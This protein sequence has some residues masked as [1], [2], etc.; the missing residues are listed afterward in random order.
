[1]FSYLCLTPPFSQN[2]ERPTG[3]HLGSPP[4]VEGQWIPCGRVTTSQTAIKIPPTGPWGDHKGLFQTSVSYKWDKDS[5]GTGILVCNTLVYL[6]VQQQSQIVSVCA[7]GGTKRRDHS[8]WG[9]LIASDGVRKTHLAHVTSHLM[10][11]CGGFR[12]KK[13]SHNEMVVR[14][15]RA[16]LP[17]LPVRGIFPSG[18]WNE[19][20]LCGRTQVN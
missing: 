8:A 10:S 5:V 15:F 16:A 17:W 20:C 18:T 2:R 14:R 12:N 19:T 7:G 11:S 1:M 4:P 3:L 9:C 13:T 6:K